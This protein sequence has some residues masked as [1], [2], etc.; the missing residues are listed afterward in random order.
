MSDFFSFLNSPSTEK[1]FRPAAV[2]TARNLRNLSFMDFRLSEGL[3]CGYRKTRNIWSPGD[4]GACDYHW[5]EVCDGITKKRRWLFGSWAA[6]DQCLWPQIQKVRGG[7]QV[8]TLHNSSM[9][10]CMS[11]QSVLWDFSSS[12]CCS[13]S[14]TLNV[15]SLKL[16]ICLGVLLTRGGEARPFLPLMSFRKTGLSCDDRRINF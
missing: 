9:S 5:R 15:D 11:N 12:S 1:R 4:Y 10:I 8:L 2:C 3:G 13:A 14:N 16:H 6:R 7:Q